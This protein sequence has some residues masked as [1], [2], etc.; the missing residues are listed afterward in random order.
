MVV[1]LS[2]DFFELLAS[3]DV[4]GFRNSADLIVDA[5]SAGMLQVIDNGQSVERHSIIA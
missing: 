2:A 1:R 5:V 4:M 3:G